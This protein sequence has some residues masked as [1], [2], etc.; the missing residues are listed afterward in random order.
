MKI[1]LKSIYI[2]NGTTSGFMVEQVQ[3]WDKIE[4]LGLTL[5][6]GPTDSIGSD[7]FYLTIFTHDYWYKKN[8][9]F[10][11]D[12][13]KDHILPLGKDILL[14]EGEPIKKDFVLNYIQ[15]IIEKAKGS[16]WREVA[17]NLNQYFDW[18][19]EVE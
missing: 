4:Y 15:N 12:R 14:P 8:Y 3:N 1:Q 2:L 13:L 19:F 6:I 11:M 10:E 7:E 18:E 9:D 17:I 16:S 5:N